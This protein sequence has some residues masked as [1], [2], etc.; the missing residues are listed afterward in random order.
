MQTNI[1]RIKAAVKQLGM[2]KITFNHKSLDF[3]FN[4][5]KPNEIDPSHFKV[6]KEEFYKLI[7]LQLSRD[8]VD[9]ELIDSLMGSIADSISL[10]DI[11]YKIHRVAYV[12][13]ENMADSSEETHNIITSTVDTQK[14]VL[15]EILNYLTQLSDNLN[16]IIEEDYKLLLGSADSSPSDIIEIPKNGKMVVKLNKKDTATLMT[17]LE[18]KG[19]VEFEETSRNR[20]I[21]NNLKYKAGKKES[22]DIVKINSDISNLYDVGKHFKKRNSDSTQKLISKVTKLLS[23]VEYEDY[24]AWLK[25]NV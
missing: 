8:K 3:T 19:L 9:K 7:G 14:S 15:L 11:A 16:Y 25:D 22:A 23:T 13:K 10:I 1:T 24:A 2:C 6:I 18:Y 12:V 4:G 5:S 20:F 17:L 21:E